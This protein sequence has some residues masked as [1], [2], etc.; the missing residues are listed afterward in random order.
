MWATK[1]LYTHRHVI[2]GVVEDV[3]RD[4]E[5]VGLIPTG[6][7]ALN[8]AQKI[9]AS[10][11]RFAMRFLSLAASENRFPLPLAV[12][13]YPLVQIIFYTDL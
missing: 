8:F 10:E 5:V 1:L 11:N 3:L 12:L 2:G 7:V 4:G 9:P 13:S 6:R